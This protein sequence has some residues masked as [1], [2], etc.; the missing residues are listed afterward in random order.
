MKDGEIETPQE[1][2][3]FL[4]S[5]ANGCSSTADMWKR[6]ESCRHLLGPLVYLT[7]KSKADA[8][9][10]WAIKTLLAALVQH[11]APVGRHLSIAVSGNGESFA[12]YFDDDER[13]LAGSIPDGPRCVIA[14]AESLYPD[15]PEAVRREL[16]ECPT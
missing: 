6:I 14:A 10:L 1:A 12:V 11:A 5:F 15:L 4:I 9:T 13:E 3:G 16:G 2:L 8:R 7:E